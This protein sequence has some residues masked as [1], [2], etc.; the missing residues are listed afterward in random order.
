MNQSS[1]EEVDPPASIRP[2]FF[3]SMDKAL[4]ADVAAGRGKSFSFTRPATEGELL[5]DALRTLR[6]GRKTRRRRAPG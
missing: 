4:E 6:A 5:D 1:P 3:D 2:L